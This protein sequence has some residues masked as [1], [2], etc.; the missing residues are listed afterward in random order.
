[1][2]GALVQGSKSR[3]EIWRDG[4]LPSLRVFADKKVN[5]EIFL[6]MGGLPIG[7]V[8]L[9]ITIYVSDIDPILL[10]IF[11][12]N[13][14]IQLTYA[15]FETMFLGRLS[16]FKYQVGRYGIYLFYIIVLGIIFWV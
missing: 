12:T 2:L 13:T 15:V 11:L 16:M 14:L 1:M 4:F 8:C 6:V 5:R 7:I 9:F 3:M 10:Y